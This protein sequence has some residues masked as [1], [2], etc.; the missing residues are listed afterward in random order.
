MSESVEWVS[1]SKIKLHPRAR[2]HSEDKLKELQESMKSWGQLQPGRGRPLNDGS[3]ELFIGQGRYLSAKALGWESIQVV[4]KGAEDQEVDVAM[5]HENLKREDLDPITE[6][7]DYQYLADRNKWSHEEVA[8]MVGKSRQSITDSLSLL[9]LPKDVQELARRLAISKSN[10]IIISKFDNDEVK[11]KVSN[12]VVRSGL[13]V[14]ETEG[15]VEIYKQQGF[16]ALKRWMGVAWNEGPVPL[17]PVSSPQADERAA[18]PTNREK[19]KAQKPARNLSKLWPG[20]PPGV[21]FLSQGG[22]HTLS[23]SSTRYKPE[24]IQEIAKTA[25]LEITP[26]KREAGVWVA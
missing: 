5:L 25:P 10:C 8:N 3:V 20:L 2:L 22:R 9:A 4:I 12:L 18:Q 24:L 14:K 1:L 11:S 26:K 16:E 17:S 13:S 6:A 19:I 15:L 21:R 7:A 23:W